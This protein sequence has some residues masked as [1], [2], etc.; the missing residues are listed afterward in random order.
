MAFTITK[1]GNPY[2]ADDWLY[3]TFGL[4]TGKYADPN[5]Y[6]YTGQNTQRKIATDLSNPSQARY[7]AAQQEIAN[8]FGQARTRALQSSQNRGLQTSGFAQKMENDL[9]AQQ[10]QADAQVYAGLLQEEQ[11]FLDEEYMYD[12]QMALKIAMMRRQE[13][14]ARQKM[15]QDFA[16][17]GFGFVMDTDWNSVS[18]KAIDIGNQFNAFPVAG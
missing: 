6:D 3:N 11:R 7:T 2:G 17:E 14:L 5:F 18:K 15:W 16:I 4:H 8:K 13:A 1:N 12:K 9:Y 10:G